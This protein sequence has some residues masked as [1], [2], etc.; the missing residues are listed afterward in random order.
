MQVSFFVSESNFFSTIGFEP[1]KKHKKNLETLQRAY[2]KCG[3]PIQFYTEAAASD[4][5]GYSSFYSDNNT[6]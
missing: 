4:K 5:D 6:E 3:W 1:N 2:Q